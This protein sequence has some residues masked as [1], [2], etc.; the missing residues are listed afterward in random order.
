MTLAQ[1]LILE[2]ERATIA[3]ASILPPLLEVHGVSITIN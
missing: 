2:A 1:I 3:S